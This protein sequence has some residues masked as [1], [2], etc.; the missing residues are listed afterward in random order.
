MLLLKRPDTLSRR[1]TR[2]GPAG[3]KRGSSNLNESDV[4]GGTDLATLEEA[5]D[6]EDSND[7]DADH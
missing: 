4:R 7:E 6:Q 3:E 2:V 1:A 5:S